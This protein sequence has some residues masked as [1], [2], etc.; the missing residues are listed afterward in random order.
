MNPVVSFI[1]IA[2]VAFGVIAGLGWYVR[3]YGTP[4]LRT[5]IY[6]RLSSVLGVAAALGALALQN[7][8]LLAQMGLDAAKIAAITIGAK[9]ADWLNQELTRR[10]TNLPPPTGG[11]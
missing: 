4:G 7:M 9:L 3:K 2:L 1:L 11:G 8:E 6:A 5:Y 10:I